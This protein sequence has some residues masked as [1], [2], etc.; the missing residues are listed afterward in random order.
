MADVTPRPCKECGEH[1]T[2]PR[3]MIR[4]A[5]ACGGWGGEA[6][7]ES[8]CSDIFSLL[9]RVLPQY[10]E[11]LEDVSEDEVLEAIEKHR[12]YSAPNYYQ[13][14]NFPDISSGVVLFRDSD[15]VNAELQPE[16]GFR[17]PMCRGVSKH[18]TECDSG[19]M[20]DEDGARRPGN[21]KA[22]GLFG[23]MGKGLRVA[24]AET[25]LEHPVVYE[26][27]MPIALEEKL[28]A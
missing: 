3:E 20:I 7:V 14:R 26:I 18:Q 28:E 13:Q 2:T 4:H 9:D 15:D 11:W 16:R 27:F 6:R 22:F 8:L 12:T 17:C 21:W 24:V 19:V 5:V 10:A 23:T 1:M 25:F